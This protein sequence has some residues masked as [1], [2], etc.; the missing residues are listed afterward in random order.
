MTTLQTTQITIRDA[1]EE[2]LMACLQLDLSYETDYVWQMD[3][4]DD[5]G[6]I[7]ISFRTVRLPRPMRVI[8]PRDAE[9]LTLTWQRHHGF[10]VAET[11]GVVRGYLTMRTDTGTSTAWV[12]DIAI[13]RAW[14]QQKLGSALLTEV[15]NRARDAGLQRLT[16]ETQT[17][18]YPGICFCQK[19]GLNFCGFNDRYYPNHDIALFFGQN[20]R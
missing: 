20:V 18:N 13:G 5:T 16:V 19:R 4:R 10:L 1:R 6:A 17:K 14:R 8:Y 7:A 9:A 2:D 3:V 15:Y 11:S 12:T